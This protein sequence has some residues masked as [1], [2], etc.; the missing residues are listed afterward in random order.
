MGILLGSLSLGVLAI[1]AAVIPACKD[2]YF[3]P[4]AV[5][6]LALWIAACLGSYLGHSHDVTLPAPVALWIGAGSLLFIVEMGF[7][8]RY[9][10]FAARQRRLAMVRQD[11]ELQESVRRCQDDIVRI[12]AEMVSQDVKLKENW[13]L[14][15]AAR[16]LAE[17]VN[18]EQMKRVL[19]KDFKRAMPQVGAYILF[20]RQKEGGAYEAKI[21]QRLWLATEKDKDALERFLGKEQGPQV[22]SDSDRKQHLIIPVV[23][24]AESLGYFVGNLAVNSARDPAMVQE[25]MLSARMLSEVLKFGLIKAMSFD[26]VEQLS[27][28]DGLTGVLR[29]GMFDERIQ[30]EVVRARG[31][32]TSLGLLILDI[33]HFKSLNDKWGHQFGDQVLRRVAG[34]IAASVYETDFVARYGGEEFAVVLPR[35]NAEGVERKAESIRQAIENERFTASTGEEVRCTISIG[36]AFYPRDAMDAGGLIR[37]A[38]QALYYA[39]NAGRNRVV[40]FTRFRQG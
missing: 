4:L 11:H 30:E 16:N 40:N 12:K 10:S 22:K 37:A 5:M 19:D 14:Y 39:K 31:F 33:D 2:R 26:E 38:D 3:K 21:R 28:I 32:K 27:R 15:N 29:R 9:F 25:L 34:V 18:F 7:F 20:V 35:A 1:M 6:G 13:A 8:Y 24:E 36:I 17:C 23:A